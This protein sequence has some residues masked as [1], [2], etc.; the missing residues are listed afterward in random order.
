MTWTTL[1]L[2]NFLMGALAF[3][4]AFNLRLLRPSR[5]ATYTQ[6]IEQLHKTIGAQ[7]NVLTRIRE[8]VE[9]TAGGIGKRV[10]ENIEIAESINSLSPELFKQCP[11]LIYDLHA[12]DQFLNALCDAMANGLHPTQREL[13]ERQRTERAALFINLYD[14]FDLARPQTK[15]D[16]PTENS[17]AA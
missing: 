7:Q 10:W 8:A 2:N 5:I 17:G 16:I 6:L 3:S 4:M 13:V 14:A 12:T 15:H 11:S 9:S 1:E